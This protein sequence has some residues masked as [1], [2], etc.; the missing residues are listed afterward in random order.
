MKIIDIA[1][2]YGYESPDGFSRAFSRFHGVTPTTAQEADIELKYYP[3]L[4]IKV[5]LEGGHTKTYRT[6]NKN[7]IHGGCIMSSKTNKKFTVIEPNSGIITLKPNVEDIEIIDMPDARIIGRTVR[8]S[9]DSNIENPVE[10]DWDIYNNKIKPIVDKLPKLIPN[11]VV[12]CT[13]DAWKDNTYASIFGV[14]APKDTPIPDGC[15]YLDLPAMLTIK[16]IWGEWL[17]QTNNRLLE[18]GYHC[19]GGIWY[20]AVII[21]EGEP[22]L[23]EHGHIGR[24][25]SQICD[26]NIPV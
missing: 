17:E 7:E 23:N 12:E 22:Y 19:G 3:R 13:H 10:Q 15:D 25:L 2:K 4:S 8:Y 6:I 9:L 14:I 20:N 21:I 26:I 1:F 18:Y 11:A 16:G 5:T 24:L